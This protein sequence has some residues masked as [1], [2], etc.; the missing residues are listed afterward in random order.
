MFCYGYIPSTKEQEDAM[1]RP[2]LSLSGKDGKQYYG[3]ANHP[4]YYSWI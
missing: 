2:G 3:M 1:K 4:I